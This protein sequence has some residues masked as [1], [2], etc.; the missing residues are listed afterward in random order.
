MKRKMA[1]YVVTACAL[2]TSLAVSPGRAEAESQPCPNGYLCLYTETGFEGEIQRFYDC[3]FVDLGR[4][5]GTDR[6]RSIIDR[7]QAGTRSTFYDYQA[8]NG[9]FTPVGYSIGQNQYSSVSGDIRIADGV[10][11]C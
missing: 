6:I 3:Q 8:V 10:R 2:V 11:V 9:H 5:W 7:Q 1:A 4:L